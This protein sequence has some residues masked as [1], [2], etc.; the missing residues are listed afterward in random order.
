MTVPPS[1]QEIINFT[2]HIN[3]AATNDHISITD[4]QS[5]TLLFL[6]TR[7]L[8]TVEPVHANN[9]PAWRVKAH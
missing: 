5:S 6:P 2:T 1:K 8:I 4:V 9:I 7:F 3:I